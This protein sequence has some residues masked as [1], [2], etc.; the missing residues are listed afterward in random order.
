MND[1]NYKELLYTYI[2]RKTIEKYIFFSTLIPSLIFLIASAIDG[3]FLLNHTF[4]AWGVYGYVAVTFFF[5]A[6][7]AWTIIGSAAAFR[8]IDTS[9]ESS[10]ELMI[11]LLKAKLNAKK[12]GRLCM[13]LSIIIMCIL[14]G[15]HLMHSY[16][17]KNQAIESIASTQE[18]VVKAF[19]NPQFTCQET[20]LSNIRDL[21][22]V[23]IYIHIP[24]NED[25]V[26][27]GL[28]RQGNIQEIRM[29]IETQNNESRQDLY[30]N[31]QNLT[32]K[33]MQILQN[34][35]IPLENLVIID[36]LPPTM[37]EAFLAG[38]DIIEAHIEHTLIKLTYMDNQS[39]Y[40][41]VRI[42]KER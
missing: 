4:F 32:G 11:T 23:D 20:D 14:Y 30:N 31:A 39:P 6:L 21:D 40:I 18:M 38:E 2:F 36:S 42:Q 16:Q 10:P 17:S 19:N 12:M 27:L 35:Q 9:Y 22:T 13:L 25:T 15:P 24:N 28:N 33:V 26:I 3:I 8:K 5:L 1:E 7:L 37:L 41:Y 29:H 34:S